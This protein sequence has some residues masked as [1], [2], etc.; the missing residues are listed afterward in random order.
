MIRQLATRR[1]ERAISASENHG[2]AVRE[3]RGQLSWESIFA[4]RR[5]EHAGMR[6]LPMHFL[7]NSAIVKF[8]RFASEMTADDQM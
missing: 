1:Y 3:V 2:W 4:Q 8:A 5:G 7:A 6:T